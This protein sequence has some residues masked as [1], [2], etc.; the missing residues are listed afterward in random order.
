MPTGFRGVYSVEF[1]VGLPAE[2]LVH[3]PFSLL[4]LELILSLAVRPR[5]LLLLARH[6]AYPVPEV[7]N[8][9]T[10]SRV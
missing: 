7:R 3:Q 6:M 8:S 4:Q 5:H 1:L 2:A 10:G 9:F